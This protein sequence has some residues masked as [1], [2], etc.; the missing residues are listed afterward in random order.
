MIIG[1]CIC[2]SEA[3]LRGPCSPHQT[4]YIMCKN[5]SCMAHLPCMKTVRE[6]ISSWNMFSENG[7]VVHE[8]EKYVVVKRKK[9]PLY[10]V[11]PHEEQPPYRRLSDI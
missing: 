3:E 1:K 10:Q 8:G 2:G 9:V 4:Y 6:S 5:M 7:F 11:I